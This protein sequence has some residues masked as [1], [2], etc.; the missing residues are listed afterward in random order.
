MILCCVMAVESVPGRCNRPGTGP[1]SKRGLGSPLAGVSACSPF[2]MG[3]TVREGEPF[4]SHGQAICNSR[5]CATAHMADT[6]ETYTRVGVHALP[7][8]PNRVSQEYICCRLLGV[9]ERD[10]S[11]KFTVISFCVWFSARSTC[12]S[13]CFLLGI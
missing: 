13:I 6:R 10:T 12:K 4:L 2:L 9:T 8:S 5:F 1:P 3:P 11:T 7:S